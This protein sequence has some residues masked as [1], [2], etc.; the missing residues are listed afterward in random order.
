MHKYLTISEYAAVERVSSQSVWRWI[1]E[2][3]IQVHRTPGG[4]PRIL[5]PEWKEPASESS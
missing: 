5:N 1:A 4:T 2:G 3:K